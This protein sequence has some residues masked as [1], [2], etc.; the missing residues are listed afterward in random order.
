MSDGEPHNTET[1][2]TEMKVPVQANWLIFP[3]EGDMKVRQLEDRLP[4]EMVRTGDP[5]GKP[6]MCQTDDRGSVPSPIWS[7]GRWQVR[8]IRFGEDRAPFPAYMLETVDHLDIHDLDDQYASELGLLTI[9]LDRAI[10]SLGD[11]GRV[12]F[13]RWGDGAYHFHVWF[14]GRPT[15]A[16][17]FSGYTLPLWGFT[18]PPLD[19]AVHDANDTALAA[20]LTALHETNAGNPTVGIKGQ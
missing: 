9:K 5:D 8:P 12:H 7:N 10:M 6:C 14:L 18:L 4:Q 3:F 15:G 20:K 13:N 11:V 1:N 19:D 2:N 17:Q 16:W